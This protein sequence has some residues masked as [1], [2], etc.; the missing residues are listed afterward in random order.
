MGAIRRVSATATFVAAVILLTALTKSLNPVYS[1][2]APPSLTGTITA[3]KTRLEG[4]AVSARAAGSNITTTVF[5]DSE[6]QYYFPA[7]APG[8]YKVWAQAQAYDAG[9]TELSLSGATIRRDFSLN[10]L[11]E[12]ESQLS[13]HLWY[14]AL[15]EDNQQDR[16]MKEVFRL[17]CMGCHSQNFTLISRYDQQGWKNIIDVMSR[18]GSY[19]YG[20]PIVAG[21]RSPNPV[22]LRFRDELS[23]YLAKARGPGP[24]TMKFTPR[25]PTGDSTLAVIREYDAP[26]AGFGLPL[27]N[28]GSD[29]SQGAVDFMDEAH[30]HTMNATLDFDGNLWM[31]DI[32]NLTHTVVKIDGKTGQASKF[33][34]VETA[35]AP[36]ANSHDIFTD[37]DGQVWFDMSSIG[38]LGRVD[39]RT[40]KI[41]VIRPPSGLRVGPFAGRDGNNGI[42]V[43]GGGRGEIDD[44]S[45]VPI[46]AMRFDTRTR[47]WTTYRDPIANV[48]GYGMT[49]DR[50]GNGWWSASNPVDGLI[51]ADATTGKTTLVAVPEAPTTKAELFSAEERALFKNTRLGFQGSG[52]PGAV[53]IRKPAGDRR[54]DVV[55]GP[56]WFGGSLIKVDTKTRQVSSYRYPYGDASSGYE[57]SVD[58][59]SNVWVAFIHDDMISKFNPTTE[60]WTSYFLPTL[61]IKTH[62]LQ[63]VTVDGRTQLAM[64][65]LGAGKCAKLEFRTREEL[66]ALKAQARLAH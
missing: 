53:A 27:F 50:Q 1:A 36:P 61:G 51:Q 22:M 18:I 66:Q 4:V 32:F 8:N 48:S 43:S 49:G 33:I 15:P 5:T 58:K 21:K 10:A 31:A 54:R 28:D 40:N 23:A 47:Q 16:R 12:F 11:R 42:W 44:D 25:R 39:P 37:D 14:S 64:C 7:L 29:W 13:G 41:E 55:W 52:R 6:G 17:A 26:E 30:H 9:R 19:A 57:A 34:V 38:A 24:S 45:S 46:K 3:T 2:A 60:Q 65:Y 20:D 35:G 59:D 62:G 56:S 63:A